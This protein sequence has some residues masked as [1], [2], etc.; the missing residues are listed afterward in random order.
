MSINIR[1]KV[2]VIEKSMYFGIVF[3]FVFS[4][5]LL[6]GCTVTIDNTDQPESVSA[7]GNI[8][9]TLSMSITH[10]SDVASYG[11]M[12]VLLPTDWNVV[13][14]S[15]V[16]SEGDTFAMEEDNSLDSPVGAISDGYSWYKANT[17][18]KIETW[19]DASA[20]GTINIAVGI[21][22]GTYNLIYWVGDEEEHWMSSSTE[23]IVVT[24]DETSPIISEVTAV[25]TPT[26]DNTPDYIFTTDE[27]G[28]ISYGGSCSSTSSSASS[29]SNTII[30]NTLSDGIYSDCTVIVTDASSNASNIITVTSFTID[31]TAPTAT[32]SPLDDATGVVIDSNLVITFDEITVSSTGN[33]TIYKTND[34]SI[35]EAIDVTGALVTSSGTTAFVINPSSN[36]DYETEYYIT[37]AITT[38]DDSSLNNYVGITVSSTWSFITLDT[39]D[40]PTID[41]SSTYNVYPTCGV[42]T[43]DSGYN[44]SD[45]ACVAQGGGGFTPPAPPIVTQTP[46]VKIINE[47]ISFKVD[48]VEMIAISETEDF[49]GVSWEPYVNSFKNSNKTLYI[50]F[51]SPEGGTSEVF[52]VEPKNNFVKTSVKEDVSVDEVKVGEEIPKE[53]KKIIFTRNL[54]FGMAGEDVKELQK[55][56]NNHGFILCTQDCGS[57]GEETTYFG[58]LTKQALIKFQDS[59]NL[60]T[61]GYFGPMTRGLIN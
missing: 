36:F 42:A 11:Y 23:E 25:T 56:L 15:L 37:I 2:Y 46:Q 26:N 9:S 49:K 22:T 24:P 50:K 1:N 58:N 8:T 34:N 30:F 10:T 48:N 38:F 7:G 16:T 29:G 31:I 45:G 13:T 47:K 44:L 57:L 33:I 61:Y 53:I 27:A 60:P 43:C 40:C 32:L 59:V 14:A 12:A 51:R 20:T 18:S 4:L 55:Y 21:T 3:L 6:S 19:N 52:V 5:F 39:P 17:V 28:T 35:I 41:N 54:E